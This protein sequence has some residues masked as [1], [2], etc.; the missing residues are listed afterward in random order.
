MANH[1]RFLKSSTLSC[2]LQAC[3]GLRTTVELRNE[4]FVTGKVVDVDGHMNFSMEEVEMIDPAGNKLKFSSFF[5]QNRLVRYVQIPES[6]DIGAS[7][8]EQ[9]EI[10]TGRGRGRGRGEISKQ[11]QKILAKKDARR[12][13]DIRNALQMKAERE[14]A[15]AAQS[16]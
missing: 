3:R 2:L 15:K 4:A 10:L 11:R 13:E 1:E 9:T 7:L 16:K 8:K 5:V 6:I 14:K 12:Q